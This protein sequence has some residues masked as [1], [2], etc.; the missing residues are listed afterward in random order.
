MNLNLTSIKVRIV[1]A[2]AVSA[3]L[4]AAAQTT[5]RVAP[6]S[7]DDFSLITHRN[8]FDVNRRPPPPPGAP[9]VRQMVDSFTL[10]GT[11]S[12]ENNLL[13]VFDGSS[14]DYHKA[15]GPGGKI[16]Q[17]TVK[18]IT[19]EFVKLVSG[20]NELELKIGMQC[21]RSEDGKW[22]VGE[23]GDSSMFANNSNSRFRNFG[24]NDR[25]DRGFDRGSRNNNFRNGSR[26]F[27]GSESRS[28]FGG[29]TSAAPIGGGSGETTAPSDPNDVVA[30]M[31]AQRA[32]QVGGNTGQND[33]GGGQFQDQ[34]QAGG[35]QG[36]NTGDQNGANTAPPE[37]RN[38]IPNQ[39]DIPQTGNP[40]ANQDNPPNQ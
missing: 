36:D 40:G 15:V 6:K 33:N 11:M 13:A 8:I 19:H 2:M 29:P 25:N 30:R 10:T 35:N 9:G 14:S 17:Y 28:T 23:G 1:A 24:R 21:R 12:F 18:E 7:F 31:M 34:N 16:S 37:T 22:S 32:A 39:N 27:G 20:T 5:N 3:C 38:P 4:A 26:S